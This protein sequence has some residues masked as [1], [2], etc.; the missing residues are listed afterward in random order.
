M[1]L[2]PSGQPTL[3][4][5]PI[6]LTICLIFLA[7]VGNSLG[8]AIFTNASFSP[9][10]RIWVPVLSFLIGALASQPCLL[11]TWLGLSPQNLGRRILCT[12]GVLI[13][14]TVAYIATMILFGKLPNNTQTE[15][16]LVIPGISIGLYLF[17]AFPISLFRWKS[18]HALSRTGTGVETGQ[19]VQF[20]IR[21]IFALM[22]AVAILVP[23]C[24]WLFRGSFTAGVPWFEIAVFIC[25]Y[26][27]TVWGAFLLTFAAVFATK[28]AA[29]W[30]SLVL[31]VAIAPVVAATLM[32]VYFASFRPLDIE[33]C[34]NGILFATGFSLTMVAVLSAYYSTGYRLRPVGSA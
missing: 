10:D 29:Y 33:N 19:S 25:L 4:N 16:M 15:V 3:S 2:N 18:R 1:N 6:V 27:L 24:Q 28:R 23:V 9:S 5:K 17:A 14:L 20:G 8:A 30:G 26:G 21:H 32:A 34:I 13:F 22:T 12:A 11:A 7:L 31:Y